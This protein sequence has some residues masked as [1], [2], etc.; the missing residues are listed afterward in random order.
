MAAAYFSGKDNLS[1][2]LSQ[3]K[4]WGMGQ[5]QRI[6]KAETGPLAEGIEEEHQDIPGNEL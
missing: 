6:N 3:D 4:A 1:E 5:E 2:A